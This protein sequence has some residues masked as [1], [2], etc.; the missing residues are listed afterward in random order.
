MSSKLFNGHNNLRV[1]MDTVIEEMMDNMTLPLDLKIIVTQRVD[2]RNK[3]GPGK[4]ESTPNW[5]R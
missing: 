3:L 5:L 1:S 2:K 4:V